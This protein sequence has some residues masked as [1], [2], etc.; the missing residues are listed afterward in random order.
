[1]NEYERDALVTTVAKILLKRAAPKHLAGHVD[2]M[3]NTHPM[4]LGAKEV[5]DEVVTAVLTYLDTI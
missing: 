2:Y 4:V 5:A 1:M 3:K